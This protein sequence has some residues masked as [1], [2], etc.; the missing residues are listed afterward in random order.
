MLDEAERR[1]DRQLPEARQRIERHV[2]AAARRAR[3]AYRADPWP[4]AVVLISSTEFDRKPTYPAWE[5][6]ARG[7][8]DRRRLP[9]G[10]VEMLREPGAAQLAACLDECIEA[11]LSG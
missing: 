4:G 1:L 2:V 5:V 8:V 3:A 10:H 9:I 7:G 11:A 6:R